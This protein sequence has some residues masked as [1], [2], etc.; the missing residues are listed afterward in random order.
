MRRSPLVALT[1]AFSFALQLVLSR[2]GTT[3]VMSGGEDHASAMPMVGQIMPDMNGM[4]MPM[5]A[6]PGS[7]PQEPPCD[8]ESTATACLVMAPCA[9]GFLTIA[10]TVYDDELAL[11]DRILAATIVMPPSRNTPPE[12]PPPRA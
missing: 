6:S 12:P 10:A 9:T 3:C 8:H 2:D 4:D 1:L 11:P 7:G 5:D